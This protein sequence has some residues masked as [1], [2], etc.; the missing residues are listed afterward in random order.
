[1][2]PAAAPSQPPTPRHGSA[3]EEG[4]ACGV[5]EEEERG[6]EGATGVQDRG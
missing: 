1:M 3:G 5:M 2:H 4:R 6:G